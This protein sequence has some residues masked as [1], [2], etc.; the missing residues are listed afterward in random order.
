MVN[1]TAAFP[2]YAYLFASAR[3]ASPEER[4][5][6]A[7]KS[8]GE[9]PDDYLEKIKSKG[10]CSP[11]T[12]LLLQV[13]ENLTPAQGLHVAPLEFDKTHLQHILTPVPEEGDEANMFS[14][15]EYG[16]LAAL[17]RRLMQY[18]PSDRVTARDALEDPFFSSAA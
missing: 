18:K 3:D 8:L 10:R 6:T 15:E 7:R 14:E 1:L 9:L 11:P 12:P 2:I 16:S 13:A 4:L 17:V 5:L